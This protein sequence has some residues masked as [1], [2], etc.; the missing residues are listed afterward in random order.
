MPRKQTW[1]ARLADNL[2]GIP[3]LFSP[4]RKIAFDGFLLFDL[5]RGLVRLWRI[6]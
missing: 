3:L 2:N 4:L 5:F 6:L 1:I